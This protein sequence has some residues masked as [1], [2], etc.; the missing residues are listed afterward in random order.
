MTLDNVPEFAIPNDPAIMGIVVYAQIY[1]DNAVAF[2]NDPLQLS[3][4]LAITLI[5]RSFAG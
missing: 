1:M 4:G 2:P 5:P 3:H